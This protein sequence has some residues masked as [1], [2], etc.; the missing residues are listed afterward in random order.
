MTPYKT[1]I[2]TIS[3]KAGIFCLL[4]L[5]L[6]CVSVR[7]PVKLTSEETSRLSNNS[8]LLKELKIGARAG[9]RNCE[10]KFRGFGQYKTS[11]LIG[12]FIEDLRETGLFKSVQF[13]D[14][15]IDTP[16]LVLEL[17]TC[18]A[19]KFCGQAE[20]GA[21]VTACLLPWPVAEDN[22]SHSFILYS[23]LDATRKTGVESNQYYRKMYWWF[24]PILNMSPQWSFSFRRK[25][26]IKRL[27][28]DISMNAE[29]IS[30]L[31]KESKK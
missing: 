28:Y 20:L 15:M 18:R 29:Q 16:D 1:Q 6:H 8:I 2:P 17:T 25:R 24:S 7:A 21:L 12:P 11:Q 4:L 27:A 5:T 22:Y 13:L 31:L 23:P 19:N 3:L 14:S 30:D 9:K 26:Y 10:G